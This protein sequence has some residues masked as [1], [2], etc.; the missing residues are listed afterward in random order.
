MQSQATAA[1]E[2]THLRW[3]TPASKFIFM[4]D[5]GGEFQLSE[6]LSERELVGSGFVEALRKSRQCRKHVEYSKGMKP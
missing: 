1:I 5:K 3:S 6:W 4:E 2:P